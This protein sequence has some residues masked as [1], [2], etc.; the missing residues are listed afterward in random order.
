MFKQKTGYSLM[1]LLVVLAMALAS[2]QPALAQSA[3]DEIEVTGNVVSIDQAARTFQVQA[4]DGPLYTVYPL[5]GFVLDT[6]HIGDAVEVDGTLNEDGSIAAIRIK[7]EAPDDDPGGPGD[8]S[9]GYYC[10]QSEV[11]HP[12][13]ARLSER[14]G[15]DY[16]TLQAWFCQG[17]GWGQ[18]MLALQTGL[19]TGDDPAGLLEARSNGLG[20]G[21]IWQSLNLIGRPEHAGPPNDADGN[22]RPDFAG[23]P[24]DADGDGRPDFTGPP[25]GHPGGKP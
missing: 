25:S 1:A 4:T 15:V 18:I 17:F 8:P 5:N 21:E 24:M 19:I 10:Q 3:G 2:V 11:P 23:P 6:L 9:D 12:F 13:G 20:W 14:Y 16:A 22:G 7:V